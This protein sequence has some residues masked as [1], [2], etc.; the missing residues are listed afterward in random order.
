MVILIQGYINTQRG[1]RAPEPSAEYPGNPRPRKTLDGGIPPGPGMLTPNHSVI[2]HVSF[3]GLDQE[4]ATKWPHDWSPVL[5]VT[6]FEP[7]P[8]ERASWPSVA[9]K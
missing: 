5:S 2:F 9:G 6:V 7:D 4:M 3:L 1:L 8:L